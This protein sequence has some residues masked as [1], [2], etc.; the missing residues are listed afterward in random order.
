MS[1]VF[2]VACHPAPLGHTYRL[3]LPKKLFFRSPAL[4]VLPGVLRSSAYIPV[5]GG[6]IPVLALGGL[7]SSKCLHLCSSKCRNEQSNLSRLPFPRWSVLARPLGKRT[8]VRSVPPPGGFESEL[9]RILVSSTI[10]A[11]NWHLPKQG[12]SN[13]IRP[14]KKTRIFYSILIA[15]NMGLTDC[16][17]QPGVFDLDSTRR[18]MP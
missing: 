4:G 10:S 6:Y 7:R 18:E 12:V 13:P 11:A 8:G 9:N 2:I 15:K 1:S 17:R 5:L 14:S 3:P 16:Q